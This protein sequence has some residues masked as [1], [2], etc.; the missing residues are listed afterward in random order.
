MAKPIGEWSGKN[1]SPKAIGHTSH[2]TCETRRG[3]VERS[4]K[5]HLRIWC[6]ECKELR[7]IAECTAITNETANSSTYQVILD[8][9]QAH[10]RSV[11]IAV[12]FTPSQK[13]KRGWTQETEIP[14]I[15]QVD[16]EV[17]EIRS[18]MGSDGLL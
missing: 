5:N 13:E 11:T 4:T 1:A 10:T 8:C 15:E 2:F 17:M 14:E 16:P 9:P 7:A 18:A 12:D 6:V 3:F